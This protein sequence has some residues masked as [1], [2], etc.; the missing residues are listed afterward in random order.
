MSEIKPDDPRGGSRHVESKVV[1][2]ESPPQ[3]R[4]ASDASEILDVASLGVSASAVER[5]EPESTERLV[6]SSDELK[7]AKYYAIAFLAV[8]IPLGLLLLG[9]LVIAFVNSLR[10]M[11]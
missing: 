5:S 4:D 8:V 6:P 1:G 10:A 9:A 7:A 2:E 3:P 11:E